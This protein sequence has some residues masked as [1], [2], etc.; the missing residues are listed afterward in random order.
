[1]ECPTHETH[2]ITFPAKIND[3]TVVK[4]HISTSVESS[5]QITHMY[6]YKYCYL[7]L[8]ASG[9]VFPFY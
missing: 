9:I 8:K 7:Q 1:M 2:E 3:F 6:A 5:N 4:K